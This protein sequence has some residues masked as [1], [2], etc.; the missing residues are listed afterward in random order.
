MN[1][2]VSIVLSQ[3]RHN[4]RKMAQEWYGLTDEQM[5]GMD[6]HHN[7]PTHIGGRNIPEHLFIYHT[8]LHV[9]VHESEFIEWA[10]KG[11]AV[12]HAE[13]TEE[14]KSLT[15]VK[16]GIGLHREKDELGRS[17]NAVKGIKKLHEAKDRNGKSIQGLKNAERLHSKKN[18]E[19]KSVNAVK[20]GTNAHRKKDEL[21]RSVEGIKAG[22]RLNARKDDKGRSINAVKAAVKA[23]AQRWMDPDH[24]DLGIKASGPLVTMQKARGYPHGPANRVRVS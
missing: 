9:A 8:T 10:R 2:E 23:N 5:V 17:I 19:G 6:V 1:R 7:P 13:K 22:E 20:A 16:A 4:Y 21:G 11:S 3:E 15:A 14:G 12:A 24:P 18:K